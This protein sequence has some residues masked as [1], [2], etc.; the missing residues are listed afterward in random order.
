MAVWWNLSLFAPPT[1][2]RS[3]W[4]AVASASP[5]SLQHGRE[6]VLRGHKYVGRSSS[7]ASLLQIAL[8]RDYRSLS[9]PVCTPTSFPTPSFLRRK[10]FVEFA[11]LQMGKYF[12]LRPY[13]I[14]L[15]KCSRQRTQYVLTPT[16][17]FEN[18]RLSVHVK[19]FLGDEWRGG[20]RMWSIN[21]CMLQT[22]V[23]IHGGFVSLIE[24]LSRV[25]L[26]DDTFCVRDE[27]LVHFLFPSYRHHVD[28]G[29]CKPHTHTRSMC[30][31]F[32]LPSWLFPINFFLCLLNLDRY[33]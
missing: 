8:L 22:N 4:H 21:A 14:S 25:T 13:V 9:P 33:H 26:V 27:I 15:N 10:L 7:L 19:L 18:I 5:N 20:A 32:F 12:L 30:M 28:I 2:A 23:Y 31:Q 6:E 1:H 29:Y 3:T 17:N 11:N 16:P 24:G